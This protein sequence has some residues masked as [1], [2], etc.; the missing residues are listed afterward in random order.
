MIVDGATGGATRVEITNAGTLGTG[1][2]FLGA[3]DASGSVIRNLV[4][5]GFTGRQL[6]LS[7][8]SGITVAGSFLGVDPSG[9]AVK[10]ASNGLAIEVCAGFSCGTSQDHL[11]G[12]TT[13]AARNVIV[14]GSSGA[15]NVN[16]ASGCVIQGNFI[17]TDVTGTT[18]LGGGIGVALVNASGTRIGGTAAG[19]GNVVTG[20]TGIVVGG[21][22]A[23]A[24]SSG[25]IIQGNII[26]ADATGTT[27]IGGGGDGVNV[28]HAVDTQIGGT[29]PGAGNLISGNREGVNG[30]SS[31]IS[32]ASVAHT[33]VQG[34]RIGTDASGVA[35][36]GNSGI[37][38]T[39]GDDA[40][41]E[42][43]VIAFNGG[44]GIEVNCGACVQRIRGNA[45]HSNGG[46]GIDL[47]G[48][49]NGVDT[50]DANDVDT[51]PNGR[52]NFPLLDPV[53]FPGGT[54]I[55]GALDST[56]STA[57]RV[58]VFAS[59]ACD[60]S[61]NGE[62]QEFV[63]GL[64]GVTTNAGGHATFTVTLDQSV[65]AGRIMTATAIAPDGSTSEFSPCT[66]APATTTSTSTS[67]TTTS[68]TLVVS[69]TSTSTTTS[70]TLAPPPSTT[71]TTTSPAGTTT[72]T[73]A[74][75]GAVPTGPTGASISCRLDALRARV[76]AEPG[77]G[78]LAAKLGRSVDQARARLAD[79]ATACRT[80]SLKKAKKRLR[81]AGAAMRQYVHRL[82]GLAARKRLDPAL[83]ATFAADGAP[84]VQ[85]L[86]TLLGA[87]RCPDDA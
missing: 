35:A 37:G 86:R 85:D 81:Q 24:G 26:G 22:P 38:I 41:I 74:G 52:Q 46:I 87:L 79:A 66:P 50:N 59:D 33:T 53:L 48:G 47:N 68:S 55:A 77:L 3:T 32:G 34:N 23:L 72:T 62:G 13:A 36:L 61:G 30:G 25:T 1:L 56:P 43:N 9:A 17:N 76:G 45:I 40:I 21:N 27:G 44:D 16:S 2:S 82:N 19:A 63:G 39:L 67:T 51:G 54:S 10:G 71:S 42:G 29:A 6:L 28:S 4:I 20:T 83:R 80:P 18:R 57:F 64:D 60:P 73:L 11:I 65:T 8:G 49:S 12:G 58:E 75:C 5:N 69:T 84:I 14:G 15:I 7:N 70:T 31:G 78:S